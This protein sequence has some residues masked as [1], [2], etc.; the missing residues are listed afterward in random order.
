MCIPDVESHIAAQLSASS[1]PQ[2]HELPI[3]PNPRSR[4]VAA[5]TSH[6]LPASTRSVHIVESQ[7]LSS[8]P[9]QLLLHSRLGSSASL[10]ASSYS[11]SLLRQ[12]SLVSSPATSL[13]SAMSKLKLTSPE[14][15]SG[16]PVK[17]TALHIEPREGSPP[18]IVPTG[19][20]LLSQTAPSY[21]R[22]SRPPRTDSFSSS[23]SSSSGP[24]SSPVS[25]SLPS[26]DGSSQFHPVLVKI[27][28][29]G[30]AT[31]SKRHYTEDIQ[32][33]QYRS[34]EA[35]VG[36]SDWNCKVDVWSVACVVRPNDVRLQ[37]LRADRHNLG[38]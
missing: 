5:L 36:R 2:T 6:V 35:I 23:S 15:P 19:P 38:V 1:P 27:A 22:A 17:N 28:D 24:P 10:G 29:L 30:N 26:F 18:Q 7:P 13:G 14:R 31:P 37:L 8:P 9:D 11:D 3:P 33:R 32:T 20:S 12:G 34:P 25:S 4:R 21:P 16:A